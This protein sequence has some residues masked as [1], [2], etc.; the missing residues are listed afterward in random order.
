MNE[1]SKAYIASLNGKKDR[2]QILDEVKQIICNDRQYTH[3]NPE[4]THR[5][6]AEFWSLYLMEAGSLGEPLTG[7]DVAVMM[8]LFK[9]ARHAVN[10]SHRDNLIDGIG[11]LAIAA[12][13]GEDNENT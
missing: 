7:Q 9:I 8:G 13:M 5:L 6:I 4:N 3:G 1:N 2:G 12:E 11:Y 10:Y